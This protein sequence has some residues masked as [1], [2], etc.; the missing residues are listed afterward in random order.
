MTKKTPVV[1]DRTWVLE[2][3][4]LE[5]VRATCDEYCSECKQKIPFMQT[6]Y[7]YLNVELCFRRNLCKPCAVKLAKEWVEVDYPVV[8]W[9]N[10][11]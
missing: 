9:F 6:Y 11:A 7:Q 5:F 3:K 1:D 2:E 4:T 10:N 8:G